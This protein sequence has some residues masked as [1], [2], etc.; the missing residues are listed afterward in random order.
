LA[1]VF[2]PKKNIYLYLYFL[3][4]LVFQALV[5]GQGR[6]VGSGVCVRLSL[7]VS[8]SLSLCVRSRVSVWVG[9]EEKD[10]PLQCPLHYIDVPYCNVGVF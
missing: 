2:S 8:L 9:R 10:G 6:P 7:L 3:C 4:S 5:A 1:Q